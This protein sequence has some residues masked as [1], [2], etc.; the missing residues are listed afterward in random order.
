MDH[1][2]KAL[3]DWYC[4]TV[5]QQRYGGDWTALIA[6]DVQAAAW[7]E[8]ELSGGDVGAVAMQVYLGDAGEL[9]PVGNARTPT[10]AVT[11]L[12]SRL[13]EV[14]AQSWKNWQH[15][16]REAFEALRDAQRDHP[17]DDAFVTRALEA[18]ELIRID[19][20]I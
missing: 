3:Q 11:A 12:T 19:Q 5:F 1:I 4:L 6:P 15:K 13:A 2:D 10:A 14:P 7:L 17:H 16:V 8:G 9:F 18:G 20:P